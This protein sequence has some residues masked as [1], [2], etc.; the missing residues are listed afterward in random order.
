M[1][2]VYISDHV[3]DSLG[4]THDI[5]DPF[6]ATVIDL[7]C[8]DT[9]ALMERAGDAD[10]L[11]TCYLPNINGDVMDAMPGLKGIIR[12]GIG[13]DTIDLEAAKARG[14]QVANV[15]DYCLDEVSDHAVALTLALN[16]KLAVSSSRIKSGDYGLHYVHPI[17]AMRDNVVTIIGYGR[18]GRRI[19]QKLSAFGC[20]LQFCDPYVDGDALAK[21]VDFEAALET[22]DVLI[23]QSPSTPQTH[24]L[25]DDAA[26]ARMKKTP[27]IVNAARG[28]L[29]DTGAL[30]RAL[31]AGVVA[32]A[33]LDVVEGFSSYGADYCLCGYENVILTPHSAW[34]SGNAMVE[35]QRLTAMEALRVLRGEKVR[36]SV[37][38]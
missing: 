16:R 24:H 25:L 10:V 18:I 29:I 5:L 4:P 12:T 9:G 26:F 36:N 14:I 34:I 11:I 19:A 3:F 23:L 8:K 7:Q 1:K 28:D 31:K 6:G 17:R 30:E 33:G 37:I 20:G 27:Y 2:K 38:H 35:L 32:G 22:S 21:K 15:P 13:Y